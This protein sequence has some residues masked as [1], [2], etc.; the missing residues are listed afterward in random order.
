MCSHE[1]VWDDNE[2]ACL[3][4]WNPL[5]GEFKTFSMDNYPIECYR[6][7]GRAVGLY[8]SSCDDD[9]RLLRVTESCNVYI[10]SLKSDSWR[11]VESVENSRVILDWNLD[12]GMSSVL[13]NENLYSFKPYKSENLIMKFNTKTEKFTEV[14]TPTIENQ[15]NSRVFECCGTN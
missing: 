12:G 3:V 6:M 10:Y 7:K 4:L 14:K 8:Y 15:I 11:K 1:G 2:Y 9:Y 13:L 5:T